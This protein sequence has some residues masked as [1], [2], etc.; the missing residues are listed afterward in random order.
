MR[1]IFVR[2]IL[3]P[4]CMLTCMLLLASSPL[5]ADSGLSRHKKMYVV[6]APGQVAIDGKLNDWDLS[7]QIMTYVESETQDM[8]SAKF[9]L[10]YDKTNL[11]LSGV[12]RDPSPMMN[13]HDPKADGGRGWD[14]DSCQFR[15]SLNPK[16]PFPLDIG[17]GHG[18]MDDTSVTHMTLWY[19]TDKQEPVL[20]IQQSMHY[21]VP[22]A[23]A[24]YGVVPD[25]Q[26]QAKY[27]KMADG[28]GYTF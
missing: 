5:F 26:F 6:P 25:D 2:P 22:A 7:G 8:Q 14:A 18:D 15:L 28:R 17:Y 4:A 16:A 19:Y 3:A 23:W 1:S 21:K 24:P 13:R 27:V 10:M 20:Q 11:Y 12:V 9:A